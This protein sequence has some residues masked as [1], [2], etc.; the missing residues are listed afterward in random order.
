M[1]TLENEE[2]VENESLDCT[3]DKNN[4]KVREK[5]SAGKSDKKLSSAK[6]RHN[7]SQDKTLEHASNSKNLDVSASK[8]G[9]LEFLQ[10]LEKAGDVESS[11]LFHFQP[12]VASNDDKPQ[13][14]FLPPL[15]TKSG[16]TYTLVL[17]LD[18]TLVHFEENEERTG[19][20]FHLRPFAREFLK[21]MSQHYELVI[22]TAA[23]KPVG[24][25]LNST[26]TGSWTS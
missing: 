2:V 15:D 10:K 24:A 25:S 14:P 16:V 20:Q 23:I 12:V 4:V 3:I 7:E 5:D 18:E 11:T 26:Q 17:D 19:G 9:F 21:T 8:K 6:N 1:Q 13:R 22:F